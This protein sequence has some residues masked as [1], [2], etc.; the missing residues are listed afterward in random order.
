MDW[1]WRQAKWPHLTWNER[2]LRRAEALFAQGAGV[3]IGA[4]KH[5]SDD[6]REG[7]SVEL[8]SQ[9]A[10][11]TSAIEGEALDRDSVHH[12]SATI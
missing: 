11:D 6:E 9:E 2:K 7:L 10:V 12:R 5:L 3:S 4:S 8:M 1:N